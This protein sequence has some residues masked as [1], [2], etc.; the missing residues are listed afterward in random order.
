MFKR[1]KMG[2]RLQDKIAI[3]TGSGS[4]IGRTTA[5]LFAAEGAMVVVNDRV[6]AAGRETADIIKESG[7][8]ACFIFGDVSDSGSAQA[9]VKQAIDAFSRVDILFNNAGGSQG[10]KG[11][12]GDTDEEDWDKVMKGNVTATFLMCKYILPFMVKNGRGSIINMGSQFGVAVVPSFA[13]YSTAKAAVIHL[14]KQ[15]SLDYGR[16][17]IRANCL[18]PGPILTPGHDRFLRSKPDYESAISERNAAVALGRMGLPEDVANAAL[19]LASDESA[20][21]TGSVLVI[22]GGY[23]AR[24]C[25]A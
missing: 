1:K 13:A 12:L 20:Y 3:V 21:F 25:S 19:F 15:M 24:L 8:Q 2:S 17:Q 16:Y 5:L 23:D 11:A 9:V 4:G 7:G 14:T 22:D 10:V 18:C 6:D